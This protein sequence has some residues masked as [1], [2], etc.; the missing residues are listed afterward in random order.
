MKKLSLLILAVLFS[1]DVQA[2]SLESINAG[3]LLIENQNTVLSYSGRIPGLQTG[4]GFLL[5]PSDYQYGLNL[6]AESNIRYWTEAV[7]SDHYAQKITCSVFCF[8]YEQAAI[9]LTSEIGVRNKI[10]IFKDFYISLLTGL[11]Y[12]IRFYNNPNFIDSIKERR[13][14]NI[15]GLAKAKVSSFLTNRAK[16]YLSWQSAFYEFNDND[17]PIWSMPAFTAGLSYSLN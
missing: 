12:E 9:S 8:P 5:V 17:L 1:F 7:K 2:Q 14:F 11:N 10:T 4:I 15:G 6:I 3:V 16:V 13:E